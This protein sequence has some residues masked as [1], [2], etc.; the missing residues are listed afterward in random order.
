MEPPENM[1]SLAPFAHGSIR[2]WVARWWRSRVSGPSRMVATANDGSDRRALTMATV[3]HVMTER[4]GSRV[5]LTCVGDDIVLD[6]R[7][8]PRRARTMAIDL[9]TAAARADY[10]ND[11]DRAAEASGEFRPGLIGCVMRTVRYGEAE[12]RGHPG[13]ADVLSLPSTNQQAPSN[14]GERNTE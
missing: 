2:G 9:F 14:P 5:T 12:R 13:G 3:D 10:E 6:A 1:T 11:F 4:H 8:S 7:L